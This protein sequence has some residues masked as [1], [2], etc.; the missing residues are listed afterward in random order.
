M[1]VVKYKVSGNQIVYDENTEQEVEKEELIDV[2]QVYYE[3]IE[4][5]AKAKAY[6]GEITIEE[7][8]DDAQNL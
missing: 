3:G 5:V 2:E 1:K 8:E 7:V 4:E 6:N